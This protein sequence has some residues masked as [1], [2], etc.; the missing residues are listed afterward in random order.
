MIDARAVTSLPPSVTK[1]GG[2]TEFLKIA[3]LCETNGAS[4]MPH[5]PYFGPGQLA[6]LHA[7]PLASDTGESTNK[8][9]QP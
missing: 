1:V 9:P 6:T 4:L 7:M 5:A 3:T 8:E 2:I